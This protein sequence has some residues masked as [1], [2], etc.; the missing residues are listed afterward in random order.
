MVQN[1]LDLC[2]CQWCNRPVCINSKTLRQ[3]PNNKF[4]LHLAQRQI[5]SNQL[6]LWEACYENITI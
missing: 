3:K 4:V 6:T 5:I 1:I 2:R